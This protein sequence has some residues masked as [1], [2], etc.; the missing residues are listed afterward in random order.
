MCHK[1]RSKQFWVYCCIYK[2][3][4]LVRPTVIFTGNTHFD[5]SVYY[6]PLFDSASNRNEYQE[7]SWRAK[8][9]RRVKLRTVSW[10][11]RESERLDVS[12]PYRPPGPVTGIALFLCKWKKWAHFLL[13]FR[14]SFSFSYQFLPLNITILL[15][16][17]LH[18]LIWRRKQIPKRRILQLFRISDDGRSP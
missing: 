16:R 7:S 9:W 4:N 3:K 2:F 18:A 5:F 14:S 15:F 10:L 17:C 8:S 11:S 6:G 13:L 1:L 12:Q